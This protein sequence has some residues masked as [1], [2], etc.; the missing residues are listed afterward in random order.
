MVDYSPNNKTVI[1]TW[2]LRACNFCEGNYWGLGDMLRGSAALYNICKNRGYNLI[3]DFSNYPVCGFLE[4]VPHKYSEIIKT[5]KDNVFFEMNKTNQELENIIMNRL[6]NS[7]YTYF[8]ATGKE[9][10]WNM[11]DDCRLF[12]KKLLIPTKEFAQYI[13]TN[14]NKENPYNV[15]HLRL[16]DNFDTENGE[17]FE[18]Y[19]KI[20]FDNIG[21]ND[22]LL[23][24]SNKF[25]KY[26][27]ENTAINV[28]DMISTHLGR[29]CDSNAARDT[30]FEFFVATKAE[31]IKTYTIYGHVSG[32]MTAVSKIYNIPL[33]SGRIN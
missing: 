6:E 5:N 25:K 14:I 26:V 31:S 24:D 28:S 19:T 23:C 17:N 8:C 30:L 15:L 27:K 9:E 3:V 16:G 21:H 10:T 13:E 7:D 1:H 4:S 18:K 33:I 2:I 32:F 12:L 29:S 20:L 11:S 22:I